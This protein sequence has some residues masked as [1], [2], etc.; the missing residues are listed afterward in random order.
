MKGFYSSRK[1]NVGG[2]ITAREKITMYAKIILFLRNHSLQMLQKYYYYVY[3]SRYI[4][5]Y[6][7]NKALIRCRPIRHRKSMNQV[8]FFEILQYLQFL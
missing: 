1:K 8:F 6:I 5:E 2:R 4:L 7:N 3:R